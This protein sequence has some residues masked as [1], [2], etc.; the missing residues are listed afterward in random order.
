MQLIQE[1][2]GVNSNFA[3][4]LQRQKT[5]E[6]SFFFHVTLTRST[7]E[8]QQLKALGDRLELRVMC[9]FKKNKTKPMLHANIAAGLIQ[10]NHWCLN[11]EPNSAYNL[12]VSRV[13]MNYFM[14]EES[15][16]RCYMFNC[17]HIVV[18]TH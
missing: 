3:N 12:L 7:G 5:A 6:D 17:I 10:K 18:R 4:R 11:Y 16:F 13:L 15:I 1:V 14:R 2:T 9:R 8:L